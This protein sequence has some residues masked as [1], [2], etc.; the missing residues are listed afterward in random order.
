MPLDCLELSVAEEKGRG[1][2]DHRQQRQRAFAVAVDC[3]RSNRNVITWRF[4]STSRLATLAAKADFPTPGDPLIQIILGPSTFLILI[5]ISCKIVIQVP[6][7]HD[8]RRGSQGRSPD[9]RA[10]CQQLPSHFLPW[11]LIP[12]TNQSS[13][14]MNIRYEDQTLLL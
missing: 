6:S 8:L 4:W 1:G 10:P 14:T 7:I 3:V 12:T 11:W 9:R 2:Q 13:Q 5:S